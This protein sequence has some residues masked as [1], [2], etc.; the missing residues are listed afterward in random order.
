[1]KTSL[2]VVPL[3]FT[4]TIEEMAWEGMGGLNR[5]TLWMD[6][7]CVPVLVWRPQVDIKIFSW[8][9]LHLIF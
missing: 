8:I 7:V 2:T 6:G 4:L 9:A 3:I 1:M 5:Y